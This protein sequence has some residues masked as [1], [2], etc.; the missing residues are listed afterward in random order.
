MLTKKVF[1]EVNPESLVAV[2]L[3]ANALASAME[4][5]ILGRLGLRNCEEPAASPNDERVVTS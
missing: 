5:A 3:G 2:F 1:G 4:P